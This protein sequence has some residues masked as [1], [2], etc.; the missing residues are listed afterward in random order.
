MV[1]G[2]EDSARMNFNLLYEL[3]QVLVFS[4]SEFPYL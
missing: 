1:E 3:R 2:K 4:G